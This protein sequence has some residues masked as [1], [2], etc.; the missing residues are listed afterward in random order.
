M[1][2]SAFKEIST[3]LARDITI[4]YGSYRTMMYASKAHGTI[5]VPQWMP[6][7]IMRDILHRAYLNTQ[8]TRRAHIFVYRKSAV[9]HEISSEKRPYHA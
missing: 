4:L 5:P 9:A 6:G 1:A 8:A 2:N 7:L 3:T